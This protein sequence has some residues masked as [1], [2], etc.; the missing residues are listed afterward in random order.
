MSK[1]IYVVQRSNILS[2]D[3]MKK[4]LFEI[5]EHLTPDNIKKPHKHTVHLQDDTGIAI[6]L[7]RGYSNIS[8]FNLL[9]GVLYEENGFDWQ[10]IKGP[11]PNGSYAI[12]RGNDE[13]AEAVTDALA[14]RTLWYLKNEDF[15][16]CSTS[17]RAIIQFTKNFEFNREV[18]PW[19]LS[20]GALGPEF[21][22]DSRIK[23]IKPDSSVILDKKTWTLHEEWNKIDLEEEKK[24]LN[25]HK[26][27]LSES[28]KTT[29]NY[30]ANI[31]FSKWLLPLSGG[32]D[33][34]AI[35]CLL[36]E[37]VESSK[38]KTVTWGD[39]AA[40][41]IEGN[42]AKIAT[43]LAKL[44]NVSNTYYFTD[45]RDEPLE[46]VIERFIKC[47]EGRIENFAGYIDGMKTWKSFYENDAAGIIR[48]DEA[49]GYLSVSSYE[50]VIHLLEFT[51][52]Q[53]FKNLAGISQKYG[54]PEQRIPSYLKK[55]EDES[56]E[57]WRDRLYQSY[58]V[59]TK[60]AAM[61]DVKLSYVE[62]I[63]PFLTKRILEM[64]R[65][66]PA[67]LRSDKKL[68]TK[69]VENIT[70]DYPISNKSAETSMKTILQDQ[71]VL[72]FLLNEIEKESS[73]SLMGDE[74]INFV[75]KSAEKVDANTNDVKRFIKKY[76][77]LVLPKAIKK[78]VRKKAPLPNL[79]PEL[80]IFRVYILVCMHRILTEDAS[81]I[82][83]KI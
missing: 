1:V 44:L 23:R 81:L 60:L 35:L 42:D 83:K 8:D 16:I 33:S 54:F 27:N 25:E 51:T 10:S 24:S 3:Q 28:I 61:S 38:I 4:S 53:D 57:N 32:Y 31:D 46:V 14:T 30:I 36:K 21:S 13:Y 77:S 11:K 76:L 18:I 52:C 55:R 37:R 17:Q 62:L 12:V 72:N 50:S 69:V 79:A 59:P 40:L 2:A 80:L 7:D 49:F 58:R 39:K 41:E 73:R 78:W 82:K 75:V 20:T 74:F 47:G 9:L 5:C 56:L 29:F 65:K 26:Q 19:M 66:L 6:S 63:S 15:F 70:P 64:V 43:E 68:F 71:K 48:G 67:D 22:W 45:T 34:R